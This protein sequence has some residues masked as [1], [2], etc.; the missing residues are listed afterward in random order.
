M[1]RL[2]SVLTVLSVSMLSLPAQVADDGA[3]ETASSVPETFLR[4]Q[5]P[6][7][8]ITIADRMDYGFVLKGVRKGTRLGLPDMPKLLRDSLSLEVDGDW[9]LDTLGKKP[10]SKKKLARLQDAPMDVELSMT[11]IPFEEGL[12][13]LPPLAVQTITP[14]GV[15]DT[16]IFKGQKMEVVPIQIDT[17]TFEINDIKGQIRDP[18]TFKEILPYAAGALALAGIVLGVIFLI[19]KKRREAS[20]E[21]HRDPPYIVALRGLEAFRGEKFWAPEKQKIL[22]SGITDTLRTYIERS[23]GVNA[24]EMTTAEIFDALKDNPDI[25]RD[26][27]DEAKSLFELSDFVKFAKHTAGEEDNLHA[28]P[29]AVRFVTS[30]YQSQVDR[31]ARSDEEE[32]EASAK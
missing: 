2:I 4:Q 11:I 24:E 19:R 21:E 20:A 3:A 6:C 14:E 18:V 9:K 27:Y 12:Y 28:I 10:S 31:E 1:K 17:A 22:Y 26:V 7:D 30:T 5:T 16:I 23:F 32:R 25:A 15:V 29:A 13:Y 8:S